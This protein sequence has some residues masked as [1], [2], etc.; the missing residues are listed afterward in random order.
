MTASSGGAFLPLLI[1]FILLLCFRHMDVFGIGFRTGECSVRL[2]VF[3]GDG[4]A[5]SSFMVRLS[6]RLHGEVIEAETR[7][8]VGFWVGRLS[9]FILRLSLVFSPSILSNFGM[10]LWFGG[11][12]Q[13]LLSRKIILLG[14]WFFSPFQC[15]SRPILSFWWLCELRWSYLGSIGV[16]WASV[17]NSVG[18]WSVQLSFVWVWPVVISAYSTDFGGRIWLS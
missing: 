13:L 16:S 5:T 8:E 3:I 17:C 2:N 1:F 10:V 15:Q 7:G 6:K 12:S 11:V 14:C 9:I 4:A 18:A